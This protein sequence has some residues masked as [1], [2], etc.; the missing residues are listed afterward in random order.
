MKRVCSGC[1]A[2]LGHECDFCESLNVKQSRI[3]PK[4]MNCGNCFKSFPADEKTA[5]VKCTVCI[6][7]DLKAGR[8]MRSMTGNETLQ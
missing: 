6:T 8:I 3:N 5:A 7:K 2:V 1:Q 4:L